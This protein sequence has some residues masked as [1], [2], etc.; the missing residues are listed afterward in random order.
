[1]DYKEL[2]EK[3]FLESNVLN[4]YIRNLKKLSKNSTDDLELHYR[5]QTLYTIY[6]ELKHT[7]EYLYHKY[8]VIKNG[9]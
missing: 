9:K 6:L 4:N 7:G 8:E 5:I 3:Y 1:M 2:S